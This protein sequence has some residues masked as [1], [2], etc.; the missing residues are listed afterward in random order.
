MKLKTRLLVSFLTIIFVPVVLVL[1]VVWGLG[2]Y[3]LKSIE[4]N[5]GIENTTY[6][7]LSNSIQVMSESTENIF[8]RLQQETRND[9]DKFM[10]CT[11][12]DSINKELREKQS[13]L[14]IRKDD[15]IIY[16]GSKILGEKLKDTLPKYEGNHVGS[17]SGIYLGGKVQMLVKQVDFRTQDQSKISLF[18]ITSTKEIVPQIKSLVLDIL[19]STVVIL[20]LTSSI[21]T[22]WIYRGIVTPLHKL[23]M[24]TTNIKEGNLDFTLSVEHEDEI[25]ELCRDFE[26]M[27][28]RLKVSAEE[29]IEFDQGNKELISNISHD[30]K[31][32][33]TAIKGY[34][35]G[36]MD[37][38]ADTPE[39][40]DR[41]IKTIYNKANDMD[42]LINELTFYSKIDTDRIPYTFNKINVSSYFE[43][44]I[45]EVGLDLEAKNINLSYSNYVDEGVQIIADAEQLRRVINN[46]IG[47][48]VKYM[49]KPNGFI[50]IR[51]QDVGD[52][53]QIEIEDNG[54]G[55]AQKDISLIFD[56]FYRTDASRNSSQGGS[57]IGLSIVKKIVEDHGGKIWATSK[58]NIGTVMHIVIRKYQEV[59]V[60]E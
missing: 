34:V 38:V 47:N 46:I 4:S 29:K 40:M 21:L 9:P 25:G 32:P 7:Y 5:Y 55:I 44:C 14:V 49:N 16:T 48:S 39:K 60:N 17:D 53:I 45:E 3:Q 37:G 8:K 50:N 58:E 52:F 13:F 15:D 28:H 41:Y 10:D 33:I 51:I 23:R 56:R 35:E 31:T 57:G 27:R 24:A 18:I 26:E 54:K 11:Y 30:L 6:E 2:K 12:L 1:I 43:D 59:P 19:I 22:M 42:R 36:I 20:I